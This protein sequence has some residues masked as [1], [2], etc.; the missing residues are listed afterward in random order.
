MPYLQV[1]DVANMCFN[2]FAK[3]KFLRKFPNLLYANST[4]DQGHMAF[5]L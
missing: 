3:I 4:V 5:G 2:A 1:F